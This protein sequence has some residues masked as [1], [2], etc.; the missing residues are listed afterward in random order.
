VRAVITS[1]AALLLAAVFA[2]Y[3]AQFLAVFGFLPTLLSEQGGVS[4]GTASDLTA[5]AVA[6]NIPGNVVGGALRARGVPRWIL[7]CGASTSWP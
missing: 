3:A 6:A 4:P 5:C 2:A 1:P 7:I